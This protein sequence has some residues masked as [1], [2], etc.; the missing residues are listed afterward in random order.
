MGHH[1]VP[2]QYL[3]NFE[4]PKR[5]GFLWLHEKQGDSSRHAAIK[6]VVQS[7]GFYSQDM[8]KQLATDVELPANKVI[9]KLIGGQRITLNE[10]S[11]LAVY[12]GTMLRRVP[13]HRRLGVG[14]GPRDARPC[15]GE[16]P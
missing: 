9:S 6:N 11:D 16:P 2:Q 13:Y 1:T 8:E 3:R 5:P 4:D 15:H 12:V 10:R 14:L 7:R